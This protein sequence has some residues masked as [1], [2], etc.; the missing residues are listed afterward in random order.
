MNKRLSFAILII[1]LLIGNGICVSDQTG[2]RASNEFGEDRFTIDAV[3][4]YS[5]EDEKNILEIYYKIFYDAFGYQKLQDGYEARYEISFNVIGEDNQPIEGIT[6]DGKIKVSS[7]AETRRSEDFVI[8]MVSFS[9]EPQDININ[10]SLTDESGSVLATISKKMSKKSYTQKYPTISRVE[11]AHEIAESTRSSKFNKKDMRI[12]PRVIRVFGGEDDSLLSFYHEVYPGR[13]KDKYTKLIIGLYHRHKGL[14]RTDTISYGEINDIKRE[15]QNINIKDI[16]PG[17]YELEL[18]LI[19]RRG[20]EYD[21][22]TEEIEMKLTGEGM[23]VTDYKKLIDMLKYLTNN[24]EHKKLKEAKTLEERRRVWDEFWAIRASEGNTR[25]NPAKAEYFRRVRHSN[26]YFTFMNRDGWK[27]TR[28]MIY[29][30]YG[31]P[32]EVEDYPFEL[33]TK[34]YQI[35][36]YFRTNPPRKFLFID[37]WGDGNYELQPPYDGLG[38]GN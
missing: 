20:R 12:I 23:F 24:K 9:F 2:Y 32:D 5:G 29:I 21:K 15:F 10:A 18:K 16:Y 14:M 4:F 7:Y 35:W 11:L 38:F 8:N 26:R 31:P 3:D 1:V 17:D 19:G 13:K 33:A 27:T 36:H 6:K 30:T 28:G 25:I 22:I 34:P 37:E